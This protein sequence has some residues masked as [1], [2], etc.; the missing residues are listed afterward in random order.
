MKDKTV[1]FSGHRKIP[2]EQYEIIRERLETAITS[3]IH[4]GYCYFGTGGAIGFDTL[5]AEMVLFPTTSDEYQKQ[6]YSV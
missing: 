3:L 1:C 2:I 5:A 4:Q 6:L